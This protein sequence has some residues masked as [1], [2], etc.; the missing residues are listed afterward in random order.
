MILIQKDWD[1]VPCGKTG[2]D[3]EGGE[4]RCLAEIR[5]PEVLDAVRELMEGRPDAAAG[6]AG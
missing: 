2:C 3:G 6:R 4:S 5:V 1:C